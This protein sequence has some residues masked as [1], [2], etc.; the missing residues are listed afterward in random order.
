MTVILSYGMGVESTAIL[1]RYIFEAAVRPC[2]LDELVVITSQ[3][4]DEYQDTGR[5]VEAHVLPLMREHRIRYVQVARKGHLEAEGI[6]ILDDSRHPQ[7][8]FLEGDYKLSDELALNGTVPQF[9]GTHRC[10]LKFK[11]WVIERWLNE[12]VRGA[13]KHALGY[14]R[15]EEKRIERSEYTL[16]ERIAFGFNVNER[17]RVERSREYNTLTREAFY[18]L[19]DWGWSRQDCLDYLES[20]LGVQWKKSACVFCLLPVSDSKRGRHRTA[21]ASIPARSPAL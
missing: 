12:N 2:S 9:G 14:N 4:G 18:P 6:T 21:I 17:D 8:V 16:R 15:D 10:T 3:V 20:M 7:R 19:L 5:D 13:A 1:V 11:A